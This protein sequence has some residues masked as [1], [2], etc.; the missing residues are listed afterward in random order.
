MSESANT[1][2]KHAPAEA[3]VEATS[4]PGHAHLP[5]RG[6]SI[7]K[8]SFGS[9]AR[10]LFPTLARVGPLRAR[11]KG[12]W[13][14]PIR[15]AGAS[16]RRACIRSAAL[17]KSCPSRRC[18]QLARLGRFCSVSILSLSTARITRLSSRYPLSSLFP[19]VPM[20]P[21]HMRLRQIW[22]GHGLRRTST[23]T[24]THPR[25]RHDLFRPL[26]LI[27]THQHQL[28]GARHTSNEKESE[29]GRSRSTE[30]KRRWWWRE[31]EGREENTWKVK[32]RSC[33]PLLGSLSVWAFGKEG[34]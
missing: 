23:H 11:S 30:N 2:V 12:M 24:H 14:L 9:Y 8:S 15:A 5:G 32:W 3:R 22:H 16:R 7:V 29:E 31:G 1:V 21:V 17:Q 6:I 28:V 25:L 10:D 27:T 20:S 34:G 33:C 26:S 18:V 4:T 19:L 13:E